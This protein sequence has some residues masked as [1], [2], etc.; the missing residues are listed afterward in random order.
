MHSAVMHTWVA[1]AACIPAP[2]ELSW[3]STYVKSLA[4]LL[5]EPEGGVHVPVLASAADPAGQTKQRCRSRPASLTVLTTV[6]AAALEHWHVPADD[7]L[8]GTQSEV[9][10]N[11]LAKLVWLPLLPSHRTQ[12]S[13]PTDGT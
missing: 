12:L 5:R 9:R 7:M 3:F 6:P 4:G 11:P 1:I 10:E 2:S 8:A 13:L